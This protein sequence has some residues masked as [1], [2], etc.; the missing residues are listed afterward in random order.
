MADK[1]CNEERLSKKSAR[2][3]IYYSQSGAKPLSCS[4]D[5]NKMLAELQA[6]RD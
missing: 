6:E 4:M 5:I 1:N 3:R 2:C